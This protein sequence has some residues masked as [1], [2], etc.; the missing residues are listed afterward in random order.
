MHS[1]ESAW[2]P[3]P[4]DLARAS[5]AV[6]SRLPCLPA[7]TTTVLQS[8]EQV[9]FDHRHISAQP[10][11]PQTPHSPQ[12][13]DTASIC[14]FGEINSF[15]GWETHLNNVCITLLIYKQPLPYTSH[16][17]LPP[18]STQRV[19]EDAVCCPCTTEAHTYSCRCKQICG[20]ARREEI[21]CRK[22][23]GRQVHLLSLLCLPALRSVQRSPGPSAEP[24]R[25]CPE[26]CPLLPDLAAFP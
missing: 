10:A 19:W 18:A 16:C 7:E 4:A 2:D 21:T 3:A 6:L 17:Q 5:L 1:S 26:G 23:L 20:Q 14:W 8:D 12:R 24:Y 25:A 11:G 22:C 15:S 13:Q 9:S